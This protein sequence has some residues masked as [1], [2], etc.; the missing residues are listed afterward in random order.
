MDT[1]FI[2]NNKNVSISKNKKKKSTEHC[3]TDNKQHFWEEYGVWGND[4]I[5]Y[6]CVHCQKYRIQKIF[7]VEDIE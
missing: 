7:F 5:I 3:V 4:R 2:K 6:K 1:G